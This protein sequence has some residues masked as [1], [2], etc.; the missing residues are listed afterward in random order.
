M[1]ILV[2]NREQGGTLAVTL[3][4][5]M[6]VG[7]VLGSYLELVGS[8]YKITTRS[9]CWN[10]AIAVAEQGIE[11]TLTHLHVEP[12]S[13][14]ANNWGTTTVGGL[15][16]YSKTRTNSNGSYFQSY[17]FFQDTNKPYVYSTGFIPSPLQD[18][19]YISRT[20]RVNT[21]NVAL[22]NV[23]FAAIYGVTLSGNGVASDSFN[24]GKTNMSNNGQY[25]PT[26]ASTN[27][28]VASVYGPV[29]LGN[30]TIN[31]SFAVGP[32]V[33]PNTIGSGQVT[34]Q[35]FTDFNVSFPPAQL[36]TNVTW[37]PQGTVSVSNTPSYDFSASGT[38]SIANAN[39]PIIVEPG[40]TATV[41]VDATSF[42]PDAVHIMSTNGISGTLILY[43]VSGSMTLNGGLTVDSGRA[44]NFYYYGLDGVTSIKMNGSSTYIGAIYAPNADMQLKGGGS[45]VN[46][47]GS[48]IV[49]SL[50]M[51]GNYDFHY[52]EDLLTSGPINP[53]VPSSWQE[54]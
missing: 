12:G 46:M 15:Q 8:R 6:C 1:K 7:I 41:R 34:G 27:G 52:D 4:V 18:G 36:P 29:N 51:T 40:V 21:T 32:E 47:V 13:P 11:E 37:V 24:S 23:A 19:Y 30:H 53:F 45:A 28:N 9:Q 54:L 48:F 31:G 33:N 3:V 17:L 14:S 25:D 39:T 2:R 42:A 35:I 10:Q 26:K 49:K 20:V 43:Q 22:F 44:R 16:A 5:A 50:T 38:Y